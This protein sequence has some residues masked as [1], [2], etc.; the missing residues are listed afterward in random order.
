M[1]SESG[2]LDEESRGLPVTGNNYLFADG[3]QLRTVTSVDPSKIF[4]PRSPGA[5]PKVFG[6]EAL[7]LMTGQEHAQRL[8]KEA[9]AYYFAFRHPRAPWYARL[10]AAGIAAY[11]FSPVQLIPSFIPVIGLL[12]DVLVLL[13][14]V[15]LLNRII[16]AD[17]LA[18]CRQLA[19]AAEAR[20]KEE[21]RST[22]AVVATVAIASLWLLATVTAYAL[23]VNYVRR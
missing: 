14:G 21:I 23:M 2:G 6:R 20:R 11:L 19:E 7:R 8:R 5:S 10:V 17:V 9:H 4:A 18:E 13:L 15:K 16:P 12:D 1:N 22:A 3:T